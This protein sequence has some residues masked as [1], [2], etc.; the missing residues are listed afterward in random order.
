MYKTTVNESQEFNI[1][2]ECDQFHIDEEKFNL[3][4]A[5]LSQ[6]RF[7]IISNGQSYNVSLI[8]QK[9]KTYTIKINGNLYEVNVDDP[10]DLLLQRLGMDYGKAGLLE[11]VK[12]PMPGMVLDIMVEEGQQVEK[13]QNL[14]ILEAMKMENVLKAPADGKIGQIE[15][16]KQDKVDKND[17]LIRFDE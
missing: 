17:V 8:E 7:H 12:A 4:V 11:D 6:S 14:I 10:Y 1:E 5:R 16:D 9:D 2:R 13:D 15:V 3:D